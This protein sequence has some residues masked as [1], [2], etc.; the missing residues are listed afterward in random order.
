MDNTKRNNKNV[1]ARYAVFV[2]AALLTLFI[3]IFGVSAQAS[4]APNP[5]SNRATVPV[6]AV[7]NWQTAYNNE[8]EDI[9][10]T[11]GALRANNLKLYI[12]DNNLELLNGVWIYGYERGYDR[13]LVYTGSWTIDQYN[14]TRP[15]TAVY[16]NVGKYYI[17]DSPVQLDYVIEATKLTIDKG[18]YWEGG[19]HTDA[20][21]GGDIGFGVFDFHNYPIIHAYDIYSGEP[22]NNGSITDVYYEMNFYLVPH[23]T[24][25]DS[26]GHNNNTSLLQSKAIDT[27][28]CMHV[29]DLDQPG[30]YYWNG[31]YKDY[32]YINA[33]SIAFNNGTAKKVYISDATTTVQG[34]R[35]GSDI[36]FHGTTTTGEPGEPTTWNSGLV[37][38]SNNNKAMFTTS[39]RGN[40]C[41]T[42]LGIYAPEFDPPI[43]GSVTLT[44][45][46]IAQGY[47]LRGND[48]TFQ[49]FEKGS[50][51]PLATT[52]NDANGNFSF[53]LNYNSSKDYGN[54]YTYVIKEVPGV[55]ETIKYDTHTET[56][57]V[58]VNSNTSNTEL[59]GKITCDSDG[60]LFKNKLEWDYPDIK[61]QKDPISKLVWT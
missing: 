22:F 49:L 28:W 41:G 4:A 5:T 6:N 30:R 15:F 23:G 20:L 12:N 27:T 40:R 19:Y 50:N 29:L 24:I 32:N 61:V 9:D 38:V 17:D 8:Q 10:I 54:T 33:E 58:K 1:S 46:K 56:V 25:N 47:K 3:S 7:A 45:K 60:V 55:G 57:K 35:D 2:V 13:Q 37:A 11:K 53:S 59:V 42:I 34:A 16:Q 44:G 18:E 51:T 43:N 39:W 36:S 21:Y 52:K 31:R 14:S 26:N 48:H